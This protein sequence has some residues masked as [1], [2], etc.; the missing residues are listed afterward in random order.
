MELP[1]FV[2]Q[3]QQFSTEKPGFKEIRAFLL[4]PLLFY[5]FQDL[6][7]RS[8]DFIKQIRR[9]WFQCGFF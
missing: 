5:V 9:L 7:E 3:N 6:L 1:A 4:L 8:L 2:E